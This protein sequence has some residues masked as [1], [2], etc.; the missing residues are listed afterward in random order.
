MRHIL[1]QLVA[2]IALVSLAC[3]A[4]EEAATPSTQ[5]DA[6]QNA[7]EDVEDVDEDVPPPGPEAIDVS[8][9]NITFSGVEIGQSESQTITIRNIGESPLHIFD[10]SIVHFDHDGEAQLIA[11]EGWPDEMVV[12]PLTF[13]DFEV[14]YE[15]TVAG[16]VRGELRIFSSDTDQPESTVRIETVSAYAELE[17]PRRISFGTVEPGESDT[18]RVEIYNRGLL[19]MQLYDVYVSED[20]VDPDDFHVE[21]IGASELPAIVQRNHFLYLDVTFSPGDEST[22]RAEIVVENS[23]PEH[24]DHIISVSG[25]RPEPC[26]QTGGDI[27]FGQ[28]ADGADA[29]ESLTLQ[30][31]S[32]TADLQIS[33]IE[34]TDDADGI[35]EL[36]DPDTTEVTVGPGL[37]H[38]LQLRATL[39]TNQ[40]VVGRLVFSTNDPDA[41]QVVRQ[42]RVGPAP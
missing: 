19:P 12:D 25:N 39:D 1:Y 38:Q 24:S 26:L 13:Y 10:T 17:A 7:A 32:A 37:S 42:L 4:T 35:F 20:S 31:C 6:G 11:G 16:S 8:P 9:S 41:S 29:T 23:D 34:I 22:R 15:P 21:I 30:N 36:V 3:S 28:L 40:E 27:D 5:E 18:Q 33:D 14:V 2:V